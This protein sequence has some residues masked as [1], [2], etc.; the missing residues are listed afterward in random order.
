MEGTYNVPTTPTEENHN[1]HKETKNKI[2]T[3]IKII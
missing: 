2:N 1:N 3:G